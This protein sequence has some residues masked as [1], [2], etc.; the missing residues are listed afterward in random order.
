MTIFNK[1]YLYI[2]SVY[3]DKHKQ[4]AN[5]LA[6]YYTSILQISLVFLLGSFLAA[7]LNQMHAS[8]VSQSQAITVLIIAAI[9]IHFSN[10][11]LY[12]G[13]SRKELNAKYA[14]TTKITYSVKILLFLPVIAVLFAFILLMS[15]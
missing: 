11:M 9:C 3:K 1:L 4:K 12:S 14:K 8:V 13:K 15:L 10:W 6:L 5:T 2:F 7:F